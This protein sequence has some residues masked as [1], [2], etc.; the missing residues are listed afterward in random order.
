MIIHQ[1]KYIFTR[2]KTGF[3]LKLLLEFI[4]NCQRLK[5]WH[6]LEEL[7]K[8]TKYINGELVLHVAII[9]VTNKV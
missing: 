1:H 9:E 3:H 4:L 7:K 6:Y 5:Q 8:I 2:L